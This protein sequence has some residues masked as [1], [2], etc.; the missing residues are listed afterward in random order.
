[1]H[2]IGTIIL[3]FT[4]GPRSVITKN[5][6]KILRKTSTFLVRLFSSRYTEYRPFPS[7]LFMNEKNSMKNLSDGVARRSLVHILAPLQK[8]WRFLKMFTENHRFFFGGG[9]NKIPIVQISIIISG[10]YFLFHIIRI[11]RICLNV[12]EP[13]E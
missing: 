10:S 7:I 3:R 13:F 2:F 8:R 5:K 11:R 4:D 1:M 6:V 12:S 9:V